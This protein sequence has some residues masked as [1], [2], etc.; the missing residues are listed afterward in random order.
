MSNCVVKFNRVNSKEINDS[1]LFLEDF[2]QQPNIKQARELT[3]QIFIENS[4]FINRY[5]YNDYKITWSWYDNVYQIALDFIS[6]K[7]LVNAIESSNPKAIILLG[8]PR[9]YTRILEMYF[10]QTEVTISKEYSF[11]KIFQELL[12]NIILL[13]FTIISI[14]YFYMR[15]GSSLAIRTED[16]IFKKTKS[17]FRLNHLYK[18]CIENNIQ[19]I[20]FIRNSSIKGFFINIYK[21]KRFAIYYSS[22]I[23]FFNL[24]SRKTNFDKK[25]SSFY[26]SILFSFH[27]QNIVFI[28][29]IPFFEKILKIIKID[30]FLLI[31][32]SSRSAHIAIAAK[33]LKI[34]VI[35][36]MHGLSQKEYVVQEFMESYDENKSIGCDIYGVWSPHY[37]DY[38]RKYSK[39]TKLEGFQYSGLLR[40]ISN[41]LATNEFVRISSNKIKILLITEPLVSTSEVIP[42]LEC[43]MKYDDIEI[44]IKVRPMI[45]DSYLE[46]LRSQLPLINNLQIYDGKIEEIGRDFDIFLGSSST[47]VIEACLIGK[48]SLLIATNKFGDYFDIDTF[49]PGESILIKNNKKLYEKIF[50]R[51][52]NEKTLNTVSIIRD[53]FFGINKDGVQWII[54]QIK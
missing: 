28:K 47:A 14:A 17:D 24:F 46:E 48:L 8:I 53:R 11:Y 51:V 52:N 10:V 41:I 2:L 26:E 22:I 44:G 13:F 42:Y 7:S 16:L 38:F 5:I 50:H 45:N 36:I 31:S 30:N 20:E 4:E 3:D 33:S 25:P 32:F 54:D 49:M 19:Y 34:K 27:Q 6:I 21:R 23:Y 29:S 9:K 15:K 40:P 37:L 43:L 18:K 35:G 12:F 1:D 39:I